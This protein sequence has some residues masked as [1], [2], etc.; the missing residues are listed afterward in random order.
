MR[1][2]R[3]GHY[4]LMVKDVPPFSRLSLTNTL[5]N[6]VFCLGTETPLCLS[7]P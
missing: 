5:V 2:A 1:L 3:D 4:P 7:L 6:R